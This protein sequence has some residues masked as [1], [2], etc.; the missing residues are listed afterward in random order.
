[1]DSSVSN[2]SDTCVVSNVISKTVTININSA[3][4]FVHQTFPSYWKKEK[5]NENEWLMIQNEILG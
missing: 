1:V 4:K 5:L 2:V 3:E